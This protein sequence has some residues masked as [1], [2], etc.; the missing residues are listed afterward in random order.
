MTVVDQTR[1]A[2]GQHLSGLLNA[3][4]ADGFKLFPP[5]DFV[6]SAGQEQIA[7]TDLPPAAF[8]DPRGRSFPCHTAAAT[9]VSA[10]FFHGGQKAAMRKKA[11]EAVERRIDEAA[12]FHG[13]SGYVA[14]VKEAADRDGR[15]TV[16]DL[17]DS[18]FALVWDY[19]NGVKERHL[20]VRN[21][22]EVKAA[23]EYVSRHRAD[24]RAADRRQ[25]AG[26]VLDKAAALGVDVEDQV[27]LRAA[28]GRGATSPEHA[29]EVVF[30][31]A[32]AV[33][34]LG[35]GSAESLGV[36]E[37]L[38][39]IAAACLENGYVATT[40]SEL[41]KLA[42]VIDGVDRE[43]RL[44]NLSD[45]PPVDSLFS[46]TEK[47]ARDV[48]A[49][50][51]ALTTGTVYTKD[52][53]SRVPLEALVDVLGEEFARA[54]SDDGLWVDRE[55]MARVA[56]TLPRGDAALLDKL[57]ESLGAESVVSKTASAPI[58]SGD[59]LLALAELHRV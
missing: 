53:V 51:V 29:A 33:K 48:M 17:P 54:V 3:V 7:G 5:P 58:E 14:A 23:A 49:G 44:R 9:W 20:P 6:K 26:K 18:D 42:D 59:D 25:I 38:A 2:N 47:V 22:G 39:K 40:P 30:K 36:S 31:R 41:H 16:D 46:L 37:Q 4:D 27:G 13:I 21:E 57:L 52:A 19:G 56:A 11:A 55:K 10:A 43:Y 32:Q 12:E 34:R 8:A 35:R 1:D 28:A 45:L 15:R 50:H 24:L